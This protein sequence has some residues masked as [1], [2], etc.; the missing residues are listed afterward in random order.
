MVP[1]T[2]YQFV[3]SKTKEL[4]GKL[5]AET[6]TLFLERAMYDI[7]DSLTSILA[8]C[9]VEHIKSIDKV[10]KRIERIN[11]LLHS[12]GDYQSAF[13]GNASFS[14]TA[15][16]GNLLNTLQEHFKGKVNF[17]RFL[18]DIHA[19]ATV[20]QTRFEE[21]LLYMLVTLIH[22]SKEAPSEILIELRQKNQDALVTVLKDQ[23]TFS[24]SSL[25]EIDALREKFEGKVQISPQG[26][27]VEIIMRLPLKFR[28]HSP[29]L[30]DLPAS[31]APAPAAPAREPARKPAPAR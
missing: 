24:V 26:Q 7:N 22:S 19:D 6:S 14:P 20:S 23:H 3:E 15:V 30:F 13:N 18:G 1:Q 2:I 8:L 29:Y 25:K 27:G 21:L 31:A 5:H 4:V 28:A 16:L 11:Q 17:V 12:I 9:D 10:K